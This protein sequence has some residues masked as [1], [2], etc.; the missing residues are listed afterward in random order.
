M[1]TDHSLPP[2]WTVASRDV[3]LPLVAY[4]D[5]RSVPKFIYHYTTPHGFLGILESKSIWATHIRHLNDRS[6]TGYSGALLD[7]TL[8]EF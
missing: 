5:R 4:T 2:T 1:S 6:E 7:K 8:S 3:L